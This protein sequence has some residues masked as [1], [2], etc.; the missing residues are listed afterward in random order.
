MPWEGRRGIK[1]LK[2]VQSQTWVQLSTVDAKGEEVFHRDY[3]NGLHGLVFIDS[4]GGNAILMD[5]QDNIVESL[6]LGAMDIEFLQ[7][8]CNTLL[9]RITQAV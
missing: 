8:S 2:L 1:M 9:N 3:E 6:L 5:D 7:E 4:E